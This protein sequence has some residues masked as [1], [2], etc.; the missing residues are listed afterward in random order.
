MSYE[1]WF[2]NG[3]GF[4]VGYNSFQQLVKAKMWMEK[5]QKAHQNIN[6]QLRRREHG[7]YR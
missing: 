7:S 2:D 5:F 6:V 1:V 3:K 4:W